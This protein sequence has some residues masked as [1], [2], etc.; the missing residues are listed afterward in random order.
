MRSDGSM[1]EKENREQFLS[2]NNLSHKIGVRLKQ[3]HG[4]TIVTADEFDS[5]PEADGVITSNPHY[6]LFVLVADCLP[7]L[8]HDPV[9]NVIAV[10]HAGREGTFLKISKK[11]I[12][13]FV[14]EYN[15][16]PEDIMVE[17]GPSIGVCCYEVSQE[18]ADLF[19]ENFGDEFVKQRNLN[20]QKINKQ[21]LIE[22]GVLE[23]NISVNSMC[24]KCSHDEYFSHRGDD[25]SERFAGVIS[26]L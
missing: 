17:I 11:M 13:R 19:S 10:A 1:K 12:E 21:Q 26:L 16:N 4:N 3:V 18:I 25:T 9:T 20:L 2:K 15:S 7:I 22:A 6:A 8:F 23:K 14:S 24:T 5:I